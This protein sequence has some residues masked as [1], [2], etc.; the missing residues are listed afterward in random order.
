MTTLSPARRLTAAAVAAATLGLL[1]LTAAC[2]K[3]EA[4]APTT[5]TTTTTTTTSVSPTEKGISPTGGNK[6]TPTVK[7]PTPQTAIPGNNN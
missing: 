3:N 5:T 2:G 4:P 1:G 7:A 6:F